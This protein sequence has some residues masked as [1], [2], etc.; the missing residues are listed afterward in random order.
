MFAPLTVL[1]D[2]PPFWFR[3]APQGGVGWGEAWVVL[4]LRIGECLGH[5]SLRAEYGIAIEETGRLRD[6]P[7]G[8]KEVIK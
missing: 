1:D 4:V 8:T 2:S 5:L 6:K 7:V 3:H